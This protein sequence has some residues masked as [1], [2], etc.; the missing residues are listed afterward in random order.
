M[1]VGESRHGAPF[2]T[3]LLGR[4]TLLHSSD[5][6]ASAPP[7]MFYEPSGC[8]Q[9]FPLRMNR[10]AHRDAPLVLRLFVLKPRTFF[11]G[12]SPGSSQFVARRVERRRG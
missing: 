11:A 5:T 8:L 6:Y 9:P 4:G 1:Q 3:V 12:P 7:L 2:D 10:E